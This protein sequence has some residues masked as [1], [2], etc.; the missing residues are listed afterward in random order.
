MRIVS[1]LASATEIV[2]ALG[3]QNH[4]VGR[5]HECD[6]PPE[7]LS[8]PV[9]SSVQID[10]HATSAH[11]DAQVRQRMGQPRP[12]DP[13]LA[14]LSIYA[15]DLELLQELRPDVI[16]TQ[17]QCEVCAVSLREVR[18]AIAQLTSLS[19]SSDHLTCPLPAPRC[20]G[21]CWENRKRS[22]LP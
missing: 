22:W 10:I 12:D 16:L 5:S 15:I 6:Y 3:Y 21:R 11:I 1:L 2:A 18:Q 14:A 7:V 13:A 17:T 19:F 20:L 4:L 9:V 8:L